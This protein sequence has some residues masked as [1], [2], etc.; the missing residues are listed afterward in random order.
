MKTKLLYLFIFIL[1]GLSLNAQTGSISA[2]S[3]ITATNAGED[4]ATI[5]ITYTSDVACSLN[6]QLRET[7]P[8]ETTTNY[9]PWHGQMD[10]TGLPAG[11]DVTYDFVYSIP[12]G[13]TPTSDLSGAG[14]ASAVQ[15]IF[16]MKL[17]ADAGGDFGYNDSGDENII[18]ILPTASPV[19]SNA[20]VISPITVSATDFSLT[21]DYSNIEA[22]HKMEWQVKSA[23]DSGGVDWGSDT[24]AYGSDIAFDSTGSGTQTITLAIGSGGTAVTLAGEQEYIFFGKLQD[25]AGAELMTLTSGVI[26]VSATARLNDINADGIVMYPNPVANMLY[27]RSDKLEAKSIKIND[28]MGRTIRVFN[29]AQNLKSLDLSGLNKGI[30]FLITD[31]KKEFKFL[32]K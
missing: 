7:N 14:T 5:T 24:A 1:S 2:I 28:I 26:S 22:E 30:Y 23:N 15:W 27:I 17:V 10:F 18:E 9:S 6:V 25:A 8:G 4:T 11:T 21:I 32:K 16:A 19:I 3:A 12:S 20:T 13:V 31:T 29:N